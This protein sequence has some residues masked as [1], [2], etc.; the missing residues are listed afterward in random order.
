MDTQSQLRKLRDILAF[1]LPNEP[2]VPKRIWE[3]NGKFSVKSMYKNLF[4]DA[5]RKPN[6]E[7][8]KANIP[9]ETKV[10]MWLIVHNPN[11]IRRK[12]KGDARCS[13]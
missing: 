3:K 9:L 7:I 1:P 10:F 6:K 2:D 5:V 12:W 4:N 8:W 13:F 11:L